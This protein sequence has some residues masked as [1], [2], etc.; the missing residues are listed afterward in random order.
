M[1]NPYKLHV[2]LGS[3]EFNGEGPEV[4]V[5]EAYQQFLQAFNAYKGFNEAQADKIPPQKPAGVGDD[6]L[7]RA[8]LKEG[9][10][11]SLRHMPPADR[12]N[13]NADAAILILYGYKKLLSQDDVLVTK[14]NESLRRSGI[15]MERVDRFIT[16]NQSL[17]RKGGQRSGG[18]YALNN[19]GEL[20]AEQWLK[21]WFN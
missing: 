5:K 9:D 7:Q 10:I 15:T 13:R 14:L 18:R 11:V 2:K 21:E 3:S 17:Y 8:F 1:E 12:P 6:L 4:A 19:Q 16:V 20:Q